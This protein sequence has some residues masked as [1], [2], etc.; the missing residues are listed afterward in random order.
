MSSK[1][2]L[3]A[4][5]IP[6]RPTRLADVRQIPAAQY[7]HRAV[8]RQA[9]Q[10]FDRAVD[11]RGRVGVRD[12]LR[13]RPVVV[14]TDERLPAGDNAY[15]LTVGVEGVW[16]LRHVFVTLADL[17]VG[18]IVDHDVGTACQ[19]LV[20]ITGVV[21]TDHDREAVFVAR[22][23]PGLGVHDEHGPARIRGESAR[24]FEQNGGVGLARKPDYL[25]EHTVE[26]GGEQ[27][28][29]AGGAQHTPTI[30]ARRVDR[31]RNAGLLEFSHQIDRR[32]E[33]WHGVLQ[34]IEEQVLL[35]V[36]EPAHRLLGGVLLLAARQR[37]APRGQEVGEPV[38]GRLAVDAPAVVVLGEW[39]VVLALVRR[40]AG[41]IVVE[42][43]LPGRGVE[44]RNVGDETV[45]VEDHRVVVARVNRHGLH[46]HVPHSNGLIEPRLHPHSARSFTRAH[47]TAAMT[48]LWRSGSDE[49]PM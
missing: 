48:V 41:Q 39:R 35:A 19:Q 7:R 5:Q 45:E 18:K 17:D 24:C 16:K 30:V 4:Y 47:P 2:W 1:P 49:R 44:R 22:L 12:D 40:P 13:E 42:C 23:H 26:R 8:R 46:T 9:L 38:E 15:Q 27:I 33:P 11:K 28:L 6:G 25:G 36:A 31:R 21:Y 37:Y 29:D 3:P 32:L 43:F 14:E 20:S 34:Q 10:G